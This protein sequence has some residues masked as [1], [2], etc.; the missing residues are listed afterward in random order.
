MNKNK[1]TCIASPPPYI[2]GQAAF[3]KE[4]GKV[5]RRERETEDIRLAQKKRK[6]S[7]F[8]NKVVC[9]RQTLFFY[10]E[11]VTLQGDKSWY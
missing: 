2:A 6:K 8:C 7:A 1:I 3:G 9:Y 11:S 10:P 5:G 4:G